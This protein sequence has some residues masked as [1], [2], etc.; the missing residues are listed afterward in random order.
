MEDHADRI[1]EALSLAQGMLFFV[2]LFA[3]A[4]FDLL[5]GKV[6]NRL[7]WGGLAAGLLLSFARG[8]VAGGP[9]SLTS[10]LAA[11]AI[12]SGVFGLFYLF[13]GLGAGD[14]KLMAAVGAASGEWRFMLW[15][16]ALTAFAGV[17]LALGVLV[18]RR[19]V[20]GGLRRSLRSLFR[21]RYTRE[22][23]AADNAPAPETPETDPAPASAPPA[24]SPVIQV[25]YAVA[26]CLGGIWT[27]WLYVHRGMALPFL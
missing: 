7:C 20:K 21:W 11:A 17:P 2:L 10:S 3:G 27:V 6:F 26:I 16:L 5:H 15:V 12:G 13:G 4:A 19:D 1:L 9:V 14:V 24:A 8:D 22:P 18:Y 23:A 25:P